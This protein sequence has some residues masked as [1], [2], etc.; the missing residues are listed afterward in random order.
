[1]LQVYNLP[2]PSPDII[3]AYEAL[4]D[5]LPQSVVQTVVVPRIRSEAAE[6]LRVYIGED[7]VGPANT[8]QHDFESMFNQA[9]AGP[10][11]EPPIPRDGPRPT[12]EIIEMT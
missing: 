11:S 6:L 9:M 12:G 5:T 1:M 2:L 3:K 8:Q 4:N 7:R 10:D